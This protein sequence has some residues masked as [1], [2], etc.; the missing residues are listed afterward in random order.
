MKKTSHNGLLADIILVG[1]HYLLVDEPTSLQINN[2]Y[3]LPASQSRVCI[4]I[5]DNKMYT[6]YTINYNIEDIFGWSFSKCSK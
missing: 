4:P 1:D 2:K 6:Q 3:L 5:R